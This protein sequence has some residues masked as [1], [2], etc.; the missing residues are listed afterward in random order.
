[1]RLIQ[2]V[3]NS[4]ATLLLSLTAFLSLMLFPMTAFADDL[5]FSPGVS[6]VVKTFSTKY[7]T[8]ISN[9]ENPEKAA[10]AASRQMIS[11]LIFSGILK[12]V[13]ALPKES[14]AEFVS[15]EIVDTCGSDLP[16]SQQDLND[17]LFELAQNGDA[18]KNSRPEPFRP[19]G[20]G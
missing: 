7:C 5:Q 8:E 19:F 17:Y 9:G 18:Q 15:T 1:M 3:L 16:I 13:M 6:D 4:C 12:E 2:L 20:V 14:L 11:G 10:E